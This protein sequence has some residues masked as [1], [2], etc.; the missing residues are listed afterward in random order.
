MST[1]GERVAFLMKENNLKGEEF[2]K[3]FN[4]SSSNISSILNDKTKPSPDLAIEICEYF[5]CTLDWFW[6]GK[7]SYHKTEILVKEPPK[8]DNELE[9][10]YMRLLEENNELYRKLNKEQTKELQELQTAHRG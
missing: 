3:I 4:K 2:A 8:S 10:K 1:L 5:G 6:A 7:G 9:K